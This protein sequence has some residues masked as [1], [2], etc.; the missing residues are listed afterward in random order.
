MHFLKVCW[1]ISIASLP[2]DFRDF[3]EEMTGNWAPPADITKANKTPF[4]EYFEAL[5]RKRYGIS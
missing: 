4:G 1:T 3:L 2:D 5:L